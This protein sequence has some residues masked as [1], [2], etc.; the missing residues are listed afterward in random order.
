[1]DV[2]SSSAVDYKIAWSENYTILGLTEILDLNIKIY[3]NPANT[4]RYNYQ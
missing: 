3:P 2:L 1:M 4:V